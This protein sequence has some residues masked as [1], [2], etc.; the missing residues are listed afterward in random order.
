[1]K[2]D[3]AELLQN[4]SEKTTPILHTHNSSELWVCRTL[5][6]VVHAPQFSHILSLSGG[7][8]VKKATCAKMLIH[9]IWIKKISSV[10]SVQLS[11]PELLFVTE[12]KQVLISDGLG[13]G[14]NVWMSG[15]WS[16]RAGLFSDGNKYCHHQWELLH[17]FNVPFPKWNPCNPTD[18]A[19]SPCIP[20]LWNLIR[21][22]TVYQCLESDIYWK[23]PLLKV[24]ARAWKGFLMSPWSFSIFWGE[25]AHTMLMYLYICQITLVIPWLLINDSSS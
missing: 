23:W 16:E 22:K 25:K 19:T 2:T 6:F 17:L 1:M 5:V 18:M 3:S 12:V 24:I 4:W 9:R 7:Y 20:P 13:R 8:G 15:T 10:M 11:L 14:F 21:A